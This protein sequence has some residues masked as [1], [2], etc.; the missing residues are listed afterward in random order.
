LNYGDSCFISLHHTKQLGFGEGGAIII[1][2]KYKEELEKIICFGYSHT[3]RVDYCT[4]ASNFKMSEVSAIYISQWLQ[5]F[6][7]IVAKHGDLLRYFFD[8]LQK[9]NERVRFF[10]NFADTHSTT[11]LS[12]LPIVFDKPVDTAAFNKYGIQAKKYY[13]PLCPDSVR[14]MDLYDR[15]VCLP[16]HSDIDYETID[17]YFMSINIILS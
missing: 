3:N 16:L 9:Y 6:N 4:Y 10:R 7:S 1:D 5:N 11:L 13:Y 8:K 2:A 15:T 17:T 14:S 12:C